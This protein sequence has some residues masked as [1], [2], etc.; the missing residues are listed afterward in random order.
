M[1]IILDKKLKTIL[2]QVFIEDEQTNPDDA[3]LTEE[4]K[5]FWIDKADIRKSHP[6]TYEFWGE[7]DPGED[8]PLW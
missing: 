6:S 3:R 1:K 8:T 4:D 7:K 2:N 5:G